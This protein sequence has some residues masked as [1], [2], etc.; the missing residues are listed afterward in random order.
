MNVENAENEPSPAGTLDEARRCVARAESLPGSE[1]AAKLELLQRAVDLQPTLVEAHEMRA[2]LLAKAGQ[3]EEAIA[4]CSPPAWKDGAPPVALRAR[5]AWIDAQ[6]GKL[7]SAIHLMQAVT[8]E[9]PDDLWIWGRLA[10]WCRSAGDRDGER[11]AVSELARLSRDEAGRLETLARRLL[12]LGGTEEAAALLR[13]ILKAD[14]AHAWA[15]HTLFEDAIAR[16]DFGEAERLH[17]HLEQHVPGTAATL[18]EVRLRCLQGREAEAFTA[19]RPLCYVPEDETH[20]LVAASDA[21]VR[22]GRGGEVEVLFAEEMER[23]GA[24]PEVAALWVQRF[25]DRGDWKQTRRLYAMPNDQPPGRRA[26][27][28]FLEEIAARR[29][30]RY[31]ARMLEREGAALHADPEYWGTVGYAWTTL[32]HHREAIRWMQDWP[33]RTVV[34]PWMLANLAVSLRELGDARGALEAS[35]RAI[36]LPPDHTTVQHQLWLAAE[37]ALSGDRTEATRLH[38]ET[39]DAELDHYFR[40]LR[41][42]VAALI[43]VGAAFRFEK[44]KAYRDETAILRQPA[45]QAAFHNRALADLR[46]RGLIAMAASAGDHMAVAK[47]WISTVFRWR[48]SKI[49]GVVIGSAGVTAAAAAMLFYLPTCSSPAKKGPS[50]PAAA[51][52]RKDGKNF[53]LP[54]RGGSAPVPGISIEVPRSGVK[55]LRQPTPRP[56]AIR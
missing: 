24:N 2:T 35:R 14:P 5:R 16:E 32:G 23:E 11:H 25:A 33:R 27:I 22:A 41:A 4:S 21:L 19:F 12:E 17:D 1:V 8:P 44:V 54:A 40:A 28:A 13:R 39:K 49:A 51:A 15:G 34:Q 7:P 42:L 10:E 43:Q 46:R 9:C 47:G 45:Y 20:R 29:R 18:A 52:P 6:R 50:S 3:W 48:S 55:Q 37:A 53:V 36:G 30:P 26:R 56:A 38:Q 31:L